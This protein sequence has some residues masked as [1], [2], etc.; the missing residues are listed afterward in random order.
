MFLHTKVSGA[1]INKLIKPK[2]T[3]HNTIFN[4][5][6]PQD[7]TFLINYSPLIANQ[8]TLQTIICGQDTMVS[9]NSTNS[10]FFNHRK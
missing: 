3:L 4:N 5:K 9:N 8:T 6:V 7:T 10:L 1:K 2:G